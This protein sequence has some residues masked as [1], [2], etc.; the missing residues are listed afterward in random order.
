MSKDA[1][2]AAKY[3]P[4]FKVAVRA[5]KEGGFWAKCLDTDRT[6]MDITKLENGCKGSMKIKLT[7]LYVINGKFG[8][9]WDLEWIQVTEHNSEKQMDYN[10]NLYGQLP[11]PAVPAMST[12]EPASTT[13]AY[14][15]SVNFD[16]SSSLPTIVGQKRDRDETPATA[17]TTQPPSTTPSEA[18]TEGSAAKRGKKTN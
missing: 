12:Q 9:T 15:S 7:S 8:C 5:K 6:P 13:E 4:T 10:E 1:E 3:D 17:A 18:V 11:T 2:K 16:G 14:Q